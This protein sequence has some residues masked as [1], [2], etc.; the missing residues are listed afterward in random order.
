M[1]EEKQDKQ[2]WCVKPLS[3]VYHYATD[4]SQWTKKSKISK[5]GVLYYFLVVCK[6]VSVVGVFSACLQRHIII[7]VPTNLNI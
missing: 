3:F 1:D 5:A 6:A 7:S 4:L 2:I